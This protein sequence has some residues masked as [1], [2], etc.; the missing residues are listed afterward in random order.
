MISKSDIVISPD[1]S[2]VHISAAFNM[3]L[4]AI[5]KK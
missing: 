4:V 3:D 1:T 2:I 5:Y